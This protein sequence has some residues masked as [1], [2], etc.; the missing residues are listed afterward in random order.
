MLKFRLAPWKRSQP[1]RVSKK[2]VTQ[3]A[4]A[5]ELIQRNEHDPEIAHGHGHVAL[6]SRS[7]GNSG[8]PLHQLP[9]RCRIRRR[10][11][12]RSRGSAWR[13]ARK[14]LALCSHPVLREDLLLLRLQHRT[15]WKASTAG[16]LSGRPA[17]RN[18]SRIRAITERCGGPPYR[19]R[20]R[21]PQRH[22]SGEIPAPHR[23]IDGAF[24]HR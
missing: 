14:Y 10:L 7:A 23:S 16:V 6:S 13:H 9:H 21:K 3:A 20:R 12:H 24:Q 5:S 1:H 11:I 8:S 18:R 2:A 22:Q 17:S 15:G 19:F 4:T